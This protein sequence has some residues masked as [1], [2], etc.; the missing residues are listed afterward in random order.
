MKACVLESVRNLVYRDVPTPQLLKDDDVLI[1]IKACGI[2]SSDIDR[3]MKTGTYHFPTI[4]GHEFSGK[5]IDVGSAVAKELLNKRAV[6]FP[7]LPCKSCLPCKKG[8]YALCENYNYFGSRCDGGFAEYIVTPVWNVLPFA[9]SLS[10]EE[11]AL[12]EPASVA[13]HAV[14]QA[15]ITPEDTVAII[16]TGT[17]GILTAQWAK[18]GGAGHVVIIGR[19][20]EKLD[21]IKSQGIAEGINSNNVQDHLELL[22]A[23]VAIECVGSPS[24]LETAIFSVQRRGRVVIVGNPIGDITLGRKTYWRILRYELMLK[25]IWNSSYNKNENDWKQTIKALEDN[26]LDVK[27]LITQTFPLN[28]CQQA[29]DLLMDTSKNTIKVMFVND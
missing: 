22:N 24:A 19:N 15:K 20:Q 4:P 29:F 28:N 7:L 9:D 23:N 11:A 26:I 2:C 25:G 18:I 8:W 6:I 3:V 21:F 16:G 14:S 10:Y 1:H 12:C 17:I 5:I 27:P 13:H